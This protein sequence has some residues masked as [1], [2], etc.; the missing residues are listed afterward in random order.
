MPLSKS[1]IKTIQATANVIAPLAGEITTRFYNNMFTNNPEMLRF[2]NKANQAS[3]KQQ[4]A[5]DHAIIA[6]ASN[7]DN[8]MNVIIIYM[9]NSFAEVG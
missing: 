8:R 2:F 3:G 1:T 5:L 4:G 7:I 9:I 6:Y